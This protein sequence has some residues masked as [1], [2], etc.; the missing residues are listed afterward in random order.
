MK[1]ATPALARSIALAVALA[2]C[3]RATPPPALRPASDEA[4]ADLRLQQELE[5]ELS[6][7][8]LQ[9]GRPDCGRACDLATRICFLAG[10]ICTLAEGQAPDDPTQA[11]CRDG[12]ARCQRARALVKSRCGC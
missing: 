11:Q 3:A 1:L 9:S 4:G 8:N 2:G 10:R 6:T 7:S 12:R 5:V